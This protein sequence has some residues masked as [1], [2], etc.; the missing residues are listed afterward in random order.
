MS[1]LTLKSNQ[2]GYKNCANILKRDLADPATKFSTGLSISKF[3]TGRCGRSA[4]KKIC[5]KVCQIVWCVESGGPYMYLGSTLV[6]F[7]RIL[8]RINVLVRRIVWCVESGC[9]YKYLGSTSVLFWEYYQ[10]ILDIPTLGNWTIKRYKNRPA[11]A[12]SLCCTLGQGQ[13]LYQTGRTGY[14]GTKVRRRRDFR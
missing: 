13:Y 4:L 12:Y 6:F 8:I 7:L 9:S 14:T 2:Y 5:I 3:S 10:W 1:F 11:C